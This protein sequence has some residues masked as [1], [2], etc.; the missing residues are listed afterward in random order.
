MIPFFEHKTSI[1]QSRRVVE[2]FNFPLHMHITPELLYITEGE[3]VINYPDREFTLGSGDFA[4]IFPYTI[5]GYTTLSEKTDYTLAIGRIDL[6]GDFEETLFNSHPSSPVIRANE[7]PDDIPKLMYELAS[8]NNENKKTMLIKSV[9][10]LIFARTLPLLNLNPNTAKFKTDLTVRAVTYV[11]EH[12][13]E[14]ISLDTAADALGISRYDVSRLF[15]SSVKV[16]F[17][18]YVNF[19]RIDY[20]KGL[21]ETTDK[22]ILEISLESGYETLRTFNRVFKE[23]TGLTPLKYRSQKNY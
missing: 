5:H 3:L 22:S 13:K 23:S 1:L 11:S 10:G 6:C 20:S 14:D 4:I 2:A 7:L 15:S 12:F 16:S 17:V 8:L 9:L 19:M 21:L 18:K